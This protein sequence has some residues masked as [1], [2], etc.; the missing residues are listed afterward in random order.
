M[1]QFIDLSGRRFDRLVVVRQLPER[2]SNGGVQWACQCDCGGETLASGDALRRKIT[3]SCGCLHKD[4][5]ISHGMRNT[6]EY[7]CWASMKSRCEN[8]RHLGFKDYGGRGIKVCQRWHAFENFFADMGRRPS[9]DHSI[10]RYPDNDGNYELG[11]CRW[12]TAKQQIDNRRRPKQK[13]IVHIRGLEFRTVSDAAKHFGV[14][15]GAV[16][17]WIK[18]QPKAQAKEDCYVT[19]I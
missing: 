19:N 12:A 5:I 14:T 2:S 15:P 16:R 17:H 6:P 10:D 7:R 4:V 8:P 3:R 11:N 1:G 18:G 9:A 13:R